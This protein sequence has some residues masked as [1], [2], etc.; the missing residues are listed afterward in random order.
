MPYKESKYKRLLSQI[1]GLLNKTD[2]LISAMATVNAI[3][4]HKMPD[5]L[6]VGFYILRNGRLLVGPYQGPLACQ[7]LEQNKGVCW[8]CMN[9]EKIVI[10]LDVDQFP[11]HIACDSR[12]KSEIALPVISE[13]G[14]KIGVLDI[15]SERTGCFDD[16]DSKYLMLIVNGM[17]SAVNL[18]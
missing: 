8:H 18:P 17:L 10:V 6:W 5:F 12:T 4:Y 16:T 15:D 14:D 2:D 13:K 3:L 7:E 1:N 11:G 9:I